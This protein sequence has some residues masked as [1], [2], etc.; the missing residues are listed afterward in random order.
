MG[1][2]Y[3]KMKGGSGIDENYMKIDKTDV[4]KI[5]HVLKNMYP[6]CKAR[7]FKELLVYEKEQEMKERRAR[8]KEIK[9][10]NRANSATSSG[11]SDDSQYDRDGVS[12]G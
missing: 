12:I 1:D 9:R 2:F 3:E 5:E 11:S 10:L 7:N 8:R 6:N 4:P